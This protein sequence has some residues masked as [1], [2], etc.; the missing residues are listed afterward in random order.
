MLFRSSTD[1][2]HTSLRIDDAAHRATFNGVTLD[3]TPVEFRLLKTLAAAPGRVFSRDRLLDNLYL[4]HRVVTDRTVD[5]HIKNLRR[6]M[7]QVAPEQD[8]I[9]SIYGVGYKLEID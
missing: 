3:L 7:E 9:R 4:D 6:K 2:S 5:S 1:T 8:P